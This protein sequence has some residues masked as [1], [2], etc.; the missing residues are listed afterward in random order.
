MIFRLRGRASLIAAA[1]LT[2]CHVAVGRTLVC[3]P[4]RSHGS[5]ALHPPPPASPTASPDELAVAEPCRGR[6]PPARS[7]S[8]PSRRPPARLAPPRKSRQWPRKPR[9]AAKSHRSANASASPNTAKPSR[10]AEA[11]PRRPAAPL[12]VSDATP[13]AVPPSRPGP[14]PAVRDRSPSDSPSRPTAR[15][16]L[17]PCRFLPV[18]ELPLPTNGRTSSTDALAD[19]RAAE[20]DASKESFR[21]TPGR[22]RREGPELDQLRDMK[23]RARGELGRGAGSH[24][25]RAGPFPSRTRRD[26]QVRRAERRQ[27]DRRSV[28]QVRPQLRSRDRE[29]VGL[30]YGG[31]RPEDARSPSSTCLRHYGVPEPGLLDFLANEID[32]RQMNARNGPRT[33]DQVRV[34][35]A[36]KL[37]LYRLP[38]SARTVRLER[39][40]QDDP[41]RLPAGVHGEP[42]RPRDA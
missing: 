3:P 36:K 22:G 8:T 28:R 38:T 21:D 30:H 10:S 15:A 33:P 6:S 9:A 18:T 27:G 17:T 35:A 1:P 41:A 34:I 19:R 4:E 26:P 40:A 20:T 24:R 23:D 14:R 2:L 11:S 32:H 25:K 16:P 5:V 39:T 7:P 29:K 42:G 37:L 13:T 12:P 31:E